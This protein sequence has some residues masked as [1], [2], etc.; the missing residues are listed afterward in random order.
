MAFGTEHA[1]KRERR[2][3]GAAADVE[4]TAGRSGG[5]GCDEKVFERLEHPIEDRLRLDPA[6]SARA[7]PELRLLVVLVRDSHGG[8]VYGMSLTILV[9]MAL[10]FAV[11]G[12]F[13]TLLPSTSTT[14]SPTLATSVAPRMYA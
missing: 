14:T 1:R 4:H 12:A 9:A 6:L 7:F 2:A 5:D 8:R 11:S 3:A 10:S 13:G